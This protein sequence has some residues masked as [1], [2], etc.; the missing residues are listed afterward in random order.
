VFLAAHLRVIFC[1]RKT[2]DY[3]FAGQAFRGYF[4]LLLALIQISKIVSARGVVGESFLWRFLL[5]FLRAS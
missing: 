4:L 2:L 3:F 1:V 5:Q